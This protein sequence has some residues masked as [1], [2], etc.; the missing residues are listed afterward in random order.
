M[1]NIQC[2]GCSRIFPNQHSLT[3]HAG[4]WCSNMVVTTADLPVAAS[5]DAL[6]TP[7][8]SP[9]SPHMEIDVSDDPFPYV[10]TMLLHH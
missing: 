9:D 1:E 7:S 2:P 4:Q 5:D 6:Y 3:V 10:T 8:T